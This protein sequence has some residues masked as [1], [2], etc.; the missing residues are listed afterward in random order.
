MLLRRKSLHRAILGFRSE[1][2]G[3]PNEVSVMIQLWL[4]SVE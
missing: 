2:R 3:T 1:R 4:A